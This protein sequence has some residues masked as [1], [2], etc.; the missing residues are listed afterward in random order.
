MAGNYTMCVSY[1]VS[2]AVVELCVSLVFLDQKPP[3]ALTLC[4]TLL[5]FLPF[6]LS[7]RYSSPFQLE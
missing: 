4:S 2:S 5:L 7:L 3:S 6:T 1:G